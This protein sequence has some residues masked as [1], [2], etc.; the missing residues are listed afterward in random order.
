MENID[1]L[2]EA[3]KIEKDII[4][5]RREIHMYP[6]LGFEEYRTSEMIDKTLRSLGMKTKKVAKTGVLGLLKGKNPGKTVAIRADMDALPMQ[7][8]KDVSYCSR[9][10]GKMHSCGHDAHTAIL[11]GTAMILSKMKDNIHGN[12]KFLFQPAEETDGGALPMIKEGVLDNPKV[13]AVFGLH[14]DDEIDCGKIRVKYGKA[15]AASDEF[16]AKIIGKSSHGAAPHNGIDAIVIA[17]QVI[18]ALQNIVSRTVNPIDSAVVT[19]GTI[20]G[21]YKGNVIAEEVEM[22]GIIRTLSPEA[23]LDVRKKVEKIIKG[24]PETMGAKS[25]LKIVPSYPSLINNDKMVDFVKE[26]VGDLLGEDKVVLKE[27][28][29]LGVEDFAYFLEKVPGAFYYLGVRNEDKGIIHPG[30]SSLFDIDE[31]SLAIGAALHAK[32]AYDFLNK[33]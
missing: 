14:C 10:P 32:L 15:N 17:G 13:D 26:T 5:L 19:I 8:K 2:A 21:G 25:E 33:N 7:D 22:S 28:P 12:V 9:V 3:K 16:Y 29:S 1:F 30:H 18:N 27:H 23:R 20:Q 11:L 6:E 31:D 24:I 4:R